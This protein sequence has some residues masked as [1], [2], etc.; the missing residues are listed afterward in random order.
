MWPLEEDAGS[1][2]TSCRKLLTPADIRK[3]VRVRV[4]ALR[5]RVGVRLKR[6]LPSWILGVTH[7]NATEM[8]PKE[9]WRQPLINF[10]FSE[11]C[12]SYSKWSH[13]AGLPLPHNLPERSVEL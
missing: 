11:R 8:T 13:I 12:Y 10:L 1:Q 2:G 9:D 7:N 4:A 6:L 5:W 3:D